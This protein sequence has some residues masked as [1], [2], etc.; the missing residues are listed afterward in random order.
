MPPLFA[1]ALPPP[2]ISM[3]PPPLPLPRR[4]YAHVSFADFLTPPLR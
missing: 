4:D 2:A 3:M 1:D